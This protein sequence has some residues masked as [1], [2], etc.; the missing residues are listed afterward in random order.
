MNLYSRGLS[1]SQK[2]WQSRYHERGL[3]VGGGG[4][5]DTGILAD[6][7]SEMEK[8]DG[9]M[10]AFNTILF[11]QLPADLDTPKGRVWLSWRQF[12]DDWQGWLDKFGLVR[13]IATGLSPFLQRET[14]KELQSYQA[15]FLAFHQSAKEVGYLLEGPSPSQPRTNVFTDIASPFADAGKAIWNLLKFV[16]IAGAILFAG[17]LLLQAWRSR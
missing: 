11:G 7:P 5:G 14:W 1:A 9:E 6:I 13:R 8:V 4:L 15:K 12:V 3:V 16:A 2:Q 17:W 10:K